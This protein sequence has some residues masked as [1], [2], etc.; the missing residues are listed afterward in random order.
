[1]RA[2]AVS[3]KFTAKPKNRHFDGLQATQSITNKAEA[4]KSVKI[5]LARSLNDVRRRSA[6][7]ETRKP[8]D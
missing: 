1:M 7:V 5:P 3:W 2:N 4:M 6:R 8:C